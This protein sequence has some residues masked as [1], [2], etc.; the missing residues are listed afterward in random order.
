MPEETEFQELKKNR[1]Y[2]LKIGG[3]EISAMKLE[4]YK[5][6]QLGGTVSP[7][8]VGVGGSK[9]E[10]DDWLIVVKDRNDIAMPYEVWA[11]QVTQ[12]ISKLSGSNVSTVSV[13]TSVPSYKTK[14]VNSIEELAKA[15]EEG[16]TEPYQFESGRW[17]LKKSR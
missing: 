1:A 3:T 9:V 10:G 17:I 16:W 15:L 11:N 2:L 5:A 6:T 12:A 4:G 13:V 8:S 14:I 7:Y